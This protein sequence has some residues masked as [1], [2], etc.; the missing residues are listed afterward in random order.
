MKTENKLNRIETNDLPQG[1]EVV[2]TARR[3]LFSLFIHSIVII[4]WG[5]IES[6]IIY[7]AVCTDSY[8]N[9][10]ILMFF[11]AV[12]GFGFYFLYSWLWQF[13]GKEHILVTRDGYL[14]IKKAI[15]NCGYKRRYELKS[16]TGLRAAVYEF[17]PYNSLLYQRLEQNVSGGSIAFEHEGDTFHFAV[18]VDEQETQIILK[19]LCK[20][21]N[22]QAG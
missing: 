17:N 20:H 8:T 11:V 3:N 18:A 19:E 22:F 7:I 6:F 10:G 1:F 13:A 4:I 5:C 15:F 21:Y 16:I 2:I 12:T 14:I 9:A